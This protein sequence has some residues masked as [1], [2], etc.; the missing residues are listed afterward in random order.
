MAQTPK[1]RR[2]DLEKAMA[3][4]ESVV[5][6]LE[7]GDLTLDKSLKQF[8]KGIRLS[9]ECQAALEAAEQK[10]KMLLDDELKDVDPDT[11]DETD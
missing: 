6:Q 8:E 5:E 11:L 7:T 9:R 2:P 10:V 3:E 1:S 4:L